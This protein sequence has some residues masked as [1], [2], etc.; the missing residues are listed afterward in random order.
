MMAR[1]LGI[2]PLLADQVEYHPFLDQD[3]AARARRRQRDFT[4]TAYSPLA[5]GKVAGHPEL[6]AIGEA[7]GKTAGPGR[8]A[9]AARPAER[10]DGAEG[11]EPRAAARRTS[12]SS[13][14]R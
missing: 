12:T 6:T 5:H 1:A 4:L 11:V 14:S 2:V 8:A 13:T 9:L 3:G 10:H 7:H